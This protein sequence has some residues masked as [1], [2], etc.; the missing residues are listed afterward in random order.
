V[1][2]AGIGNLGLHDREYGLDHRN[3][4]Y[5]IVSLQ[6]V[7]P[8]GGS[9]NILELSVVIPTKSRCES[10]QFAE[11]YRKSSVF[12]VSFSWGESAGAQSVEYHM[13]A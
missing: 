11:Y 9:R 1:Q 8:S 10:N 13:V 6:N 7:K 4:L 5:S 12:C 2:D 3:V